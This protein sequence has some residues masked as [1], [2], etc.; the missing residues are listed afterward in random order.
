MK[1]AIQ[2]GMENLE[3]ALQSKGFE[4]VPFRNGG[5]NI[6]I[7]ILNGIDEEYEEMDPVTFMGEGLN[8]MVLLDAS[9]LDENKIIEYVE[10]YGNKDKLDMNSSFDR[11]KEEVKNTKL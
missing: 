9:R 2:T 10:K 5:E 6:G 7:T 1:I 3:N 4:V 11:W 8:Q